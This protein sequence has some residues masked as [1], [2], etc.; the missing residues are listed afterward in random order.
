M[1]RGQAHHTQTLSQADYRSIELLTKPG[2]G[3]LC[4]CGYIFSFLC[5]RKD[6][7]KK[8][9]QRENALYYL[10]V[11]VRLS[12]CACS[13]MKAKILP[14]VCVQLRRSNFFFVFDYY[15]YIVVSAHAC[16]KERERVQLYDVWRERPHSIYRRIYLWFLL[17]GRLNIIYI[18]KWNRG[19]S[20][21]SRT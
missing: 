18:I 11:S 21:F 3:P 20:V 9:R 7:K 4:V 2:G 1:K 6:N 14:L 12:L 5:K 15:K 13:L 10:S 17:V 8:T 19:N 16:E